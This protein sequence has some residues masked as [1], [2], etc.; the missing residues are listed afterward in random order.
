F[1]AS[2]FCDPEKVLNNSDEKPSAAYMS[3]LMEDLRRL[4]YLNSEDQKKQML[5]DMSSKYSFNSS[6]INEVDQLLKQMPVYP[7]DPQKRKTLGA[8]ARGLLIQDAV[9]NYRP[10]NKKLH[11]EI[12]SVLAK[13]NIF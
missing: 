11:P 12:K 3:I 6:L 9:K 7:N 8:R 4:E 5:Q 10:G 1:L 2:P 13:S